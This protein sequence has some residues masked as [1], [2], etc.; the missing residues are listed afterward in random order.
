MTSVV[1]EELPPGGA[2]GSRF[3][4]SGLWFRAFC[5][6]TLELPE[7]SVFPFRAKTQRKYQ[8]ARLVPCF[9]FSFPFLF[10][11]YFRDMEIYGVVTGGDYQHYQMSSFNWVLWD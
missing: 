10:P 11:L 3:S 2:V 5:S 8:L 9:P 4:L 7:F 1:H 6:L